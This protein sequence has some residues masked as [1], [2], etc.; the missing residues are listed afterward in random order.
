MKTSI[1]LGP[2]GGYDEA[3]LNILTILNSTGK[4]TASIRDHAHSSP[5]IM[6]LV[7]SVVDVLTW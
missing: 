1:N 4:Y 3:N 2:I 5:I 7:D 6:D